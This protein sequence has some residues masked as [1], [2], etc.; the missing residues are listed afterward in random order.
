[1]S[2][3]KDNGVSQGLAKDGFYIDVK[4]GDEVNTGTGPTQTIPI[5]TCMWVPKGTTLNGSVLL[6]E[7]DAK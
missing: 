1:M 6:G 4:A 7:E 2:L 3:P 5:D